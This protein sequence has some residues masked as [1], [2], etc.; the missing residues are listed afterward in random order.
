M[1]LK[2]LV[3]VLLLSFLAFTLHLTLSV[4]T[5]LAYCPVCTVAITGA[6]IAGR[7]YGV[8]DLVMGTLIGALMVSSALWFHR[9]LR[10]RNDKKNYMPLQH[11][12][13]VLLF[14]FLTI[15][16]YYITGLV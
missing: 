8:S 13:L 3:R 1:R 12:V 9:T 14:L 6:V 15:L 11:V 7:W 2:N 16:G 5:A 10:K 4:K